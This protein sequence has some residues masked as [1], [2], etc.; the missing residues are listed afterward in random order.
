VLDWSQPILYCT[1]VMRVIIVAA[2]RAWCPRIYNTSASG[3]VS[4]TETGSM[5]LR[6]ASAFSGK[7]DSCRT[8]SAHW[9]A[10]LAKAPHSWLM[11]AALLS[12]SMWYYV[13]RVWAPPVDIHFS[14]LYPRW[15]GARELLLR[16]SDPYGPTVTR[17]IQVWSYG[18]PVNPTDP[19]EPKDE[20]RFTYPVYMAF[21]LAPTVH[22]R[23]EIVQRIFSVLLPLLAFAAVPLWLLM[24]GWR[25]SRPILGA[26]LLLSFTSFPVLE[27][28]YVQQPVLLAAALLAGACAALSRGH[29]RFAGALLALATIKPQLCALLVLWLMVW[30]FSD[31]RCRRTFAWGFGITMILLAGGSEI[32]VP[33]WIGE[34]SEAIQA[35]PLYTGNAS[36]LTLWFG[37]IGGE[38]AAAVIP[39]AVMFLAAR[40]RHRPA[41]SP[42]FHYVLCS[43]L[44]T[45][46]VIIPTIY[47]TGQVVL[48]PAQLLLLRDFQKIWRLGSALRLAYFAVA[49]LIAWPW[50]SSLVFMFTAWVRPVSELRK[51]W[52]VP[53][54]SI[55]LI[56]FSTLLLFGLMVA[57]CSK[58]AP[59]RKQEFPF[60][61]D[62]E[63]I[64]TARR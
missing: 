2:F 12:F 46:L 16:G 54:S 32:L 20:D 31:W 49:S 35:Y 3:S 23:F 4:K 51:L 21:L 15:Y 48:L 39:A 10:A 34:F 64:G 53:V 18:R 17:G 24:L 61:D 55:P 50:V 47:P 1:S 22:F 42:E 26:L 43:I 6:D 59:L 58:P 38:I 30:A 62:S 25:P 63:P 57:H 27:S 36:I 13:D 28:I 56:P 14:D 40:L 5:N 7:P 8:N 37:K 33:G 19:R 44:A 41:E 29:L 45:T 52:I 11:V 60:P 9:P